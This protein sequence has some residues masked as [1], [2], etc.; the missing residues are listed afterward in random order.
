MTSSRIG[1]TAAM[2]ALVLA[3]SSTA[4]WCQ[5]GEGLLGHLKEFEAL[6]AQVPAWAEGLPVVAEGW[7]GR[8][9]R[10]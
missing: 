10:K 4:A 9:Y 6:M 2:T 1:S 7:R 8:R 5:Q 3:L